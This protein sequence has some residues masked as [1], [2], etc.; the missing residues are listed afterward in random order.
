M[1]EGKK[2]RR[3]R[4]RDCMGRELKGRMEVEERE[5]NEMLVIV[6]SGRRGRR[7]KRSR[8]W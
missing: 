4:A 7:K 6:G 8:W 2:R 1:K 3:G 5:G